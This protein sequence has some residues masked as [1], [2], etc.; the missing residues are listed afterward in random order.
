[1]SIKN[2]AEVN[3]G[4]KAGKFNWMSLGY[5]DLPAK[6]PLMFANSDEL[7]KIQNRNRKNK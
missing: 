3:K 6:D 5:F 2:K 4:I 1:M 7:K